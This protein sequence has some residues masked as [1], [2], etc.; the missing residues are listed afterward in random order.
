MTLP[1][2]HAIFD[3][4]DHT[5]PA[6][7]IWTQGPFTM[8]RNA[9]GGSRVTAATLNTTA[10]TA[11]IN[12]AQ[13]TM[14][15]MGQPVLF[16]VK[17]GQDVFDTQ[18][19]AAGYAVKDPVILFA[20]STAQTVFPQAPHKTCFPVWP[21]LTVQTDIW[22]KGG[23]GPAQIDIMHRA[24]G[25]KTSILGRVGERPA[26][27]VY[28]ALHAGI[29]MLHTLEIDPD[30]RRRGLGKHLTRSVAQWARTQ[31]ATHLTLLATR[32]NIG[33]C[34]LY[35]SLGM[36]VVGHYHYRIKTEGFPP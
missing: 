32:A 11:D 26:G 10:T 28:A 12:T 31:N 17:D 15:Q 24:Q 18:L 20:A 21:P 6:A 3:V 7:V 5:W 25:P 14:H 35:A 36:Q 19:A 16:R 9:G 2:S 29:A 33:A 13:N 30:F 4:I 1:D 34:A 27:T 8:R 23:I 22:T